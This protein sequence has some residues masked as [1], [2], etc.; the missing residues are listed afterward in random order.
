MPP[1]VPY[2]H[3]W[4]DEK[5]VS[6]QKRCEMSAFKLESISEGAAPSWIDKQSTPGATVLVVVQPVGWVGEW[7]ENPKPQWI[8]PLS[9]RWFVETMDGKRV[10]MGPGE[11]SF[12]GDQ[13]TKPDAQG[14]K[15]H[16]SGT[17][18]GQ[19]SVNLIVQL[20]KDPFAGQP[21]GAQDSATPI[22]KAGHLASPRPPQ[23]IGLLVELTRTVIPADNR[24]TPEKTAR[25]QKLFFEGRLSAD[26]TVACTTCH[27]PARAFT[28]GRPASV[29]IKGRIGQRNAPTVLNALYNKTQFWDGRAKTLEEQAAFPIGNPDEMGQPIMDAAVTKIAGI[30]EYKQAFQKVFGR[31]V[32]GPDLLRA[33]ASYERSLVSFDSPFDHFIAGDKNAIDDSAR[34]GWDLF[35]TKALCNRC[36]ALTDSKRDVTNFMDNDFHNIGI[37]IIRHDVVALALKAKKLVASGDAAAIDRAAI[38]TDMSAL[39]RFLISKKEADT[40]ARKRH[41]RG[42]ARNPSFSDAHR[43]IQFCPLLLLKNQSEIAIS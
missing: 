11:V 38:G 32:N 2:W 17:V 31:P 27:D 6:H 19:P 37:G 30:E 10:E 36:H 26:G 24:Q 3:V 1:T 4:T 41:Q 34:R 9:G 28:D 20:E 15:G 33:I 14:R 22:P 12:G 40:S 5:G 35:N 21:C 18:G 13:I 29:G 7:H 43:A 25:G 8:I 39:G 16:R 23:Q 42:S